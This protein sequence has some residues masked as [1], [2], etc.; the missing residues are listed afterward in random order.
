MLKSIEKKC[1]DIVS[2]FD[3]ENDYSYFELCDIIQIFSNLKMR[4]EASE[5]LNKL[6]NLQDKHGTFDEE[7]PTEFL[8]SINNFFQSFPDLNI[9]NYIKN[10]KRSLDFLESCFDDKYLLIY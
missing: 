9:K 8:I 10:I 4:K 1:S 3:I 2:E 5:F 7:N 6:I